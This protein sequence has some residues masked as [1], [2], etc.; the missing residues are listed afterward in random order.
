MRHEI[1]LGKLMWGNDFP[2]PEGSW[3]NTKEMLHH[4]FAGVPENEL[5]LLLGENAAK[6]YN[7]DVEKLAP[8]VERVGPKVEEI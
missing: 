5:R 8:I 2:H 1:G 3:P 4:C 6:F 7:V